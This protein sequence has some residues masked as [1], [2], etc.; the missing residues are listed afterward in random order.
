MKKILLFM[1]CAVAACL[2]GCNDDEASVTP[3]MVTDL[4]ADSR[5]GEIILRWTTPDDNTIRF[6]QVN[7]HDLLTQTDQCRLASVY[8]DS[9]VIPDTRKR[10]GEYSF[11]V[12]TVSPTGEKSEVQ[13][14]T[15]TSLPAA[16]TLYNPHNVEIIASMLST[17]AQE[18]TEGDIANLVDGNSSTYFCTDWHGIVPGPH[19]FQIALPKTIS[20]GWQFGYVNRASADYDP[21]DFD[22]MGSMDG[23]TWY[24]VAHFDSNKY[25][26]PTAGGASYTS[27]VLDARDNPFKYLR[28]IVNDTSRGSVFFTMAEFTMYEYD[29][30]DPE[31]E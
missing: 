10:L 4:R 14:I 12:R 9:I 20:T 31:Q 6:I 18:E 13:T 7:Y 19:W 27:P 8:A 2:T 3:S 15:A 21:T 24:N 5:P 25:D 28:F 17:N 1:I 16:M 22:I 29:I 30:L 26:L 23:E 11:E